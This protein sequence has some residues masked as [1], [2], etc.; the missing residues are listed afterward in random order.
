MASN[1]DLQRLAPPWIPPATGRANRSRRVI[2]VDRRRRLWTLFNTTT[3]VWYSGVAGVIASG[4][5]V[6]QWDE[7][8]GNGINL[9][10]TTTQRPTVVSNELNGRSIIRF[11]GTTNSLRNASAAVLRNVGAATLI[12]V[13]RRASNIAA[14]ATFISTDTSTSSV[15]A[16]M[17]YR[18]TGG[19][20]ISVG[21]RRL[22]ANAFQGTATTTPYSADWRIAIGILDYA[23]ATLTYF[24]NGA[25]I[26]T[27]AFQT[28]GNT[29]NSGGVLCLGASPDGAGSFFNG[30]IA[31]AAIIHSA[32]GTTL[33]QQIEGYLGHE[34]ALNGGLTAGHPF[35]TFPP[36]L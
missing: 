8:K 34:W 27:G 36:Y 1:H 12:A 17:A 3:A 31:E 18:A 16:L 14:S 11:N 35:L 9:T 25:L 24:E 29:E 23:N 19:E 28:P 22:A 32:I 20:G 15:R 10:A 26:A 2:T 7:R 6:G 4:G 21:G 30:D 5:L 13:V 33:R